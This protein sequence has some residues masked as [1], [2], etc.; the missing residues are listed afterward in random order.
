[1]T[2]RDEILGALLPGEELS[3]EA[4]AKRLF[5]SRNAVWKAV[6]QLRQE[7][8]R[9]EG[10]TNRGYR[11]VGGGEQLSAASLRAKLGTRQIEYRETVD[12]TNRVARSMA[13][14]GA[15]TGTVVV[16]GEQTAGRG[17]LGRTFSSRAGG[18]LYMS[19]ILRPRGLAVNATLLTAYTAVAVAEA[20]EE[21][22]PGLIVGI[23]WVND[24]FCRGRKLA[25]ILCEGALDMENGQLS[26]VVVGVGVNLSRE[27]IPPE[28]AGIAVSVG[29]LTGQE[30]DPAALCASIVRRLDLADGEMERKTFL[31]EYR[32]RS[33]VIGHE[34][35][36]CRGEERFPAEV[37]RIDDNAG[38]L[39]RDWSGAE[40]VLQSGEISVRLSE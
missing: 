7:G 40:S 8:Y 12:S 20:L 23:K 39:V 19:L 29:E 18:G 21:I 4:L 5:V 35:T 15:E 28:L 6:V 10:G 25:G 16:A 11:L 37:L 27:A 26:Y 34:V 24:L 1:M 36:V 13:E 9:I 33:I 30:P 32:R 14:S 38:L 31:A 2:L 17:R 22:A 3:G